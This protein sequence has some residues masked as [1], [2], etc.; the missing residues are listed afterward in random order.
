MNTDRPNDLN[1]DGHAASTAFLKYIWS[2]LLLFFLVLFHLSMVQSEGLWNSI[3]SKGW[4]WIREQVN[5]SR[6]QG[7]DQRSLTRCCWRVVRLICSIAGHKLS[8]FY[9][10]TVLQLLESIQNSHLKP[11]EDF[12]GPT[13]LT[14]LAIF[15]VILFTQA[16]ITTTLEENYI[17][18]TYVIKLVGV[19]IVA[20]LDR[21]SYVRGVRAWCSSVVFEREAR[22]LYSYPSNVTIS[23]TRVTA[24]SRITN[25]LRFTHYYHRISLYEI[26]Y[27]YPSNITIS[28]TR[29]T[30][31]SRITN[32]L[33]ITHYYHRMLRNTQLALRTQVRRNILLKFTL[34]LVCLA[35]YS[36]WW[37]YE[38]KTLTTSQQ[39]LTGLCLLY[40][41]MS[42]LQICY[43]YPAI[44]PFGIISGPNFFADYYN[45]KFEIYGWVYRIFY[46]MPLLPEVAGILDWAC[47]ST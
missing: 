32:I 15:F 45:K 10:D 36:V 19:L 14:Q 25:I 41:F 7:S 16:N 35:M 17:E 12:Y 40:L 39:I 37:D 28:L 9:K 43:G 13:M 31:H 24:H 33:R 46:Y 29:V 5:K 20:Y 21:I 34:H 44:S 38:L 6:N 8:T 27:S 42:S 23:L 30:A 47:T 4:K 22:D 11:G 3:D 18:G 1:L 2:D 26:L